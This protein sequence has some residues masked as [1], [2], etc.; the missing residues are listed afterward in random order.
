MYNFDFYKKVFDVKLLQ[1]FLNINEFECVYRVRAS[2]DDRIR[3]LSDCP[4]NSGQVIRLRELVMS[5][6]GCNTFEEIPGR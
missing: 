5:F 4:L 1:D 2:N 6:D 3:A